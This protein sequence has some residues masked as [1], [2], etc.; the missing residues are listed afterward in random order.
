MVKI[1]LISCASKKLK[2]KAKAKEIYISPLFKLNIKYALSLKPDK[3]FIL[4]AKYGLLDLEQEI[5]PYNLTLNN[6]KEDEIKS[7]A[8]KILNELSRQANLKED[9]FIFLA[10][11]KYRK[12]IIP[13]INNYKIPLKGLGIGKQLKFLKE[14]IK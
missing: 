7:W 9:E 8:E 2:A 3:I 13:K 1:V 4:S 5:E 14:N 6:F 12:Y 11:E 10:G